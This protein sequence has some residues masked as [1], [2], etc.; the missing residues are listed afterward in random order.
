MRRRRDD[1]SLLVHKENPAVYEYRY[2]TNKLTKLTFSLPLWLPGDETKY[3]LQIC[4]FSCQTP[5]HSHPYFLTRISL[6]ETHP[7]HILD[8]C[9]VP[10][11]TFSAS[12]RDAFPQSA[13]EK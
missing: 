4:V 3:Q 1:I 6:S 5:L 13:A 10:G 11:N 7:F 8:Q 2:Y 9:V 12:L